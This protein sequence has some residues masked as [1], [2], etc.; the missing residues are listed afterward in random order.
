[1][2]MSA[3]CTERPTTVNDR[4]VAVP[5]ECITREH[6]YVCGRTGAGE[7][8]SVDRDVIVVILD[9]KLGRAHVEAL[10]RRDNASLVVAMASDAVGDA[11]GPI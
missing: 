10:I 5:H 8:R 7:A 9:I 1:M 2:T 6:P 11:I 3:R 4:I